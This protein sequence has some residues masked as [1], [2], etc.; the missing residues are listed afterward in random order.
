MSNNI[1]QLQEAKSKF[2]NLVEKALHQGPQ[3][4]TK[5][6]NNAVVILSF[7]EYQDI[8]KPESDLVAFLRSSPLVD[9]ELDISRDKSPP[10]SIEL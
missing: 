1:W 3:F 7:K 8:I 10:R 2:S 9:I 5:H 4:V 6:G